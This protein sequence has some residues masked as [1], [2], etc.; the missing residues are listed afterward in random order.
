VA[1]PPAP[2]R[3]PA[4]LRWRGQAGSAGSIAATYRGAR[5]EMAVAFLCCCPGPLAVRPGHSET[6]STAT[7]SIQDC[8][9][10]FGGCPLSRRVGVDL[11]W[12]ALRH[13]DFDKAEGLVDRAVGLGRVARIAALDR[14]GVRGLELSLVA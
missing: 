1:G 10:A 4:A 6:D 8:V 2:A 13:L 7:H 12:R 14:S 9:A 5:C 3:L 11:L